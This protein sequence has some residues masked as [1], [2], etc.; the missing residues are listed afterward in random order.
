MESLQAIYEKAYKAEWDRR[1]DK[2]PD[3]AISVECGGEKKTYIEKNFF[4]CGF[5]SLK[6]TANNHMNRR[7]K[8]ELAKQGI[9][10]HKAYGGG[11]SFYLKEIGQRGNGDF[12]IQR[13]AYGAVAQYLDSLA[14]NVYNESRLD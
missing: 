8:K 6:Y 11:F 13:V 5:N 2:T 1:V 12:E 4:W 7:L 3:V 10:A 14:Y 9:E